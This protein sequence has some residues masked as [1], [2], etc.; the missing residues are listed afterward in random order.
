MAQ[1]DEVASDR[2]DLIVR[3]K[4]MEYE[5]LLRRLEALQNQ[6]KA[7][8]EEIKIYRTDEFKDE[9]IKERMKELTEERKRPKFDWSD[10]R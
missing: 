8:I 7:S 5:Q 9:K 10:R 2:Y 3:Q 4:Q 1:L 6:V